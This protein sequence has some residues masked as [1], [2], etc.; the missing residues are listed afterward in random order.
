VNNQPL[1][2]PLPPWGA[3]DGERVRFTI[4]PHPTPT[5]AT[6]FL[7]RVTMEGW[8]ADGLPKRRDDVIA[9]GLYGVLHQLR[10]RLWLEVASAPPPD[11]P[12]D[13]RLD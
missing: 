7:L 8:D 9:E 13:N 12:A 11:T 5:P 6:P 1:I 10:D 4:E 3:T 2:R